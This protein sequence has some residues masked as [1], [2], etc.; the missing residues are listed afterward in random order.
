QKILTTGNKK[1]TCRHLSAL[2]RF[3]ST[4][5]IT[6]MFGVGELPQAFCRMAAV[7]GA[8]YVLRRD[9]K[10]AVVDQAEGRRVFNV[11]DRHV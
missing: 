6:P 1:T 3:G 4:A 8:V 2:G 7:H 11:R 10:A 9:I 5:F